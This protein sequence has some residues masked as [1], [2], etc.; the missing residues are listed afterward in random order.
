MAVGYFDIYDP[1]LGSAGWTAAAF[2]SS[3]QSQLSSLLSGLFSAPVVARRQAVGASDA[4]GASLMC[5]PLGPLRSEHRLACVGRKRPDKVRKT[6]SFEFARQ[7][8]QVNMPRIRRP[9]LDRQVARGDEGAIQIAEKP[10]T[11][12]S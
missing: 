12:Q 6:I 5:L 3:L 10:I 9:H 4:G 11:A 8:H 1:V 2:L 7:G